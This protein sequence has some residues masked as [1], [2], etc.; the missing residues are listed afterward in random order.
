[1]TDK[2]GHGAQACV[3]RGQGPKNLEVAIKYKGVY[4]NDSEC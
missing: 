4:D 1:M 3:H 2:L